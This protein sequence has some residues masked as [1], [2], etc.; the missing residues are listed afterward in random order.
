[1]RRAGRI[2][3]GALAG[4]TALGQAAHRG[5]RPLE[6]ANDVGHRDGGRPARERV[7][8]LDAHPAGHQ[9]GATQLAGDLLQVGRW[10]ALE[11][12][13]LCQ[14]DGPLAITAPQAHHH[15]DPVF[16]PSGESH[17]SPTGIVGYLEYSRDA[18][19]WAHV[20]VTYPRERA[21]GHAV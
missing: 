19:E 14:R 6:I 11:F 1:M 3:V 13:E 9:P 7:T 16:G 10:Q 21:S 5:Q 15:A 2:R 20:P 17:G 18:A 12:G 4:T 8:A